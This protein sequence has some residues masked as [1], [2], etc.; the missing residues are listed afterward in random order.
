M[1]VARCICGEPVIGS[2]KQP[3]PNRF[4]CAGCVSFVDAAIGGAEAFHG[5]LPEGG[6]DVIAF[7]ARLEKRLIES[8]LKQAGTVAGA[9]RL[10]RVN[11]TTLVEK[12]KRAR[13]SELVEVARCR[14]G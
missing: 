2:H 9:A 14:G 8:A 7:M 10:L 1:V 13:A 5:Y 12:L 11:R 3:H 4:W 6:M